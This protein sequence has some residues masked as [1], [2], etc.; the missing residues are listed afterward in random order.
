MKGDEL[1]LDSLAFDDEKIPRFEVER[2]PWLEMFA[3][4]CLRNEPCVL[5]EAFTAKWPARRQW[6]AKNGG[7]DFDYLRKT[8]G[9][10]LVP[11]IAEDQC[12]P[13]EMLFSKFCD[14]C[15]NAT[16]SGDSPTLYLKDWHFQKSCGVS[17]YVT[18]PMLQSDW[19][20]H[21]KWTDDE[22]NPFRGDYRF[23]YFGMRNS[24]TKFH[25]DVMSS[26]SWSANVCGRKLWLFVPPGKED[27][28]LQGKQY[29][30]DI[31]P[32]RHLWKE[33]NVITL[34]QNPGEIVFVPSNWYH[35]V[36][37]MEVAISINHNAVNASNIHL[38][39]QMLQRRLVEVKNEIG[40]L[41]NLFSREEMFQQEQFVLGADARLNMPRLRCLLE[42]VMSDRSCGSEVS[43]YICPQH[44][45]PSDCK[46]T[47]E[48]IKRF[49]SQCR[50]TGTKCA[51][52]HTFMRSFE[53]SMALCLLEKLESDGF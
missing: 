5:T 52:C 53:L 16:L 37:N 29:P 1:T 3:K 33:A 10:Q 50:C 38:V 21:E 42:M 48:C 31:R 2:T 18:P 34:V 8:Y 40:H 41:S 17:M 11:V 25:S 39:Y 6:V 51:V 45:D 19:A 44:P 43:C 7:P 14:Y 22:Y 36:H 23:V 15:E 46:K 26:H 49:G 13:R 32:Y 4:F 30:E 20:N 47:S 28:F 35:Q 27:V 24:W 12:E 9:H